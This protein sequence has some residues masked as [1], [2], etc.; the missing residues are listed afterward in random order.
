MVAIAHE[1]NKTVI[2]EHVE[3]AFTFE[4]LRELGVD[5]VQGFH[6]GRPSARFASARPLARLRLVS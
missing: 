4:T 5:L 1:L 6:F 2:A 3:D